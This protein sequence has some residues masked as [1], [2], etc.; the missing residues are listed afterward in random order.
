[1]LCNRGHAA[2]RNNLTLRC[3]FSQQDPDGWW[4]VIKD[5]EKGLVPGA[6]IRIDNPFVAVPD[7]A[8]LAAREASNQRFMEYSRS[9]AATLA[10]AAEN[11]SNVEYSSRQRLCSRALETAQCAPMSERVTARAR[12]HRMFG[13]SASALRAR[14]QSWVVQRQPRTRSSTRLFVAFV[15]TSTHT[16]L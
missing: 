5:G 13:S 15:R 8:I 14:R 6:Y 16:D 11:E 10:Q 3:D 7:T 1:V 4:F 9:S 2:E 12:S